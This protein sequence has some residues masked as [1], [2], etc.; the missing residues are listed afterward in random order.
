MTIVA[1]VNMTTSPQKIKVGV[2]GENQLPH[3]LEIDQVFIIIIFGLML[4]KNNFSGNNGRH[5]LYLYLR[6]MSY[7]AFALDAQI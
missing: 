6:M 1:A 5:Y 2:T 7:V 4:K 3:L